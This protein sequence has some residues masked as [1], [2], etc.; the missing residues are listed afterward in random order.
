M[1]Y[2]YYASTLLLHKYKVVQIWPGQTVACLH[3]NSPG[4]IWTTLYFNQFNIIRY[5]DILVTVNYLL[6]LSTNYDCPEKGWSTETS[7]R[8]INSMFFIRCAKFQNV[9]MR[10]ISSTEC[11]ISGPLITTSD[12]KWRTWST[13]KKN[14]RQGKNSCSHSWSKYS[15]R[16]A[17]L[18]VCTDIAVFK[19]CL[20]FE[21]LPDTLPSRLKLNAYV[22]WRCT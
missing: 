17:Q 6:K 16:C 8:F 11:C 1:Q 12:C 19:H 22:L 21:V 4:H 18:C 3:T 9:I 5:S 15:V 7:S 2:S 20:P 13:T 10:V 14:C